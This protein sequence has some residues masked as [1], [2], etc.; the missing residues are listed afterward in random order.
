MPCSAAALARRAARPRAAALKKLSR[1]AQQPWQRPA[2]RAFLAAGGRASWSRCPGR[3]CLS[4]PMGCSAC[5]T[6]CGSQRGGGTLRS[7]YLE[8]RAR[9][10]RQADG[11]TPGS[12]GSGLRSEAASSTPALS[13]AATLPWQASSTRVTRGDKNSVP[14][15]RASDE[16]RGL[17]QSQREDRA[18]TWLPEQP[19]GASRVLRVGVAVGNCLALA[20]Q[21]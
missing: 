8:E 11:A 10:G 1:S 7:A 2:L 5:R 14:Q 21:T 3:C 16:A 18:A 6:V 20:G 13:R 15:P 19:L 12:V 4:W 17:R 9:L